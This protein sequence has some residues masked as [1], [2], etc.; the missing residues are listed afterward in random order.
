MGKSTRTFD[1]N[2][3]QMMEIYILSL[4]EEAKNHLLVG[5]FTYS[6]NFK[7]DGKLANISQVFKLSEQTLDA[8]AKTLTPEQRSFAKEMQKF[9]AADCAEAGNKVSQAMY[10][11]DNFTDKNYFPM[12]SSSDYTMQ[13]TEADV[14]KGG[15]QMPRLKNMG[16][17]KKLTPRA[18]NPLVIDGFMNSWGKHVAQMANY[19]NWTLPLEDIERIYKYKLPNAYSNTT[20]FAIELE[21]AY[22]SNVRNYLGTLIDDLNGGFRGGS[23]TSPLDTLLSKFKKNAVFMSAS[24][25]VQQPSAILRAAAY[26]DPKYFVKS[27]FHKPRSHAKSWAE[28]K[29]YAPVAI[30]KEMGG[31][32]MVGGQSTVEWLTNDKGDTIKMTNSF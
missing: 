20:T 1:L 24:V 3:N 18:S 32:D 27:S 8:I 17:T 23:D 9:L 29:K 12:K 6:K 2:L 11:I 4:R 14:K 31:Y 21:K 25:V 5:G 16:F 19:S 26:I 13:L 22:G 28:L 7:K 15:A 10:G 30:V